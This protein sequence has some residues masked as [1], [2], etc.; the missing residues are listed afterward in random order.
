MRLLHGL[1]VL[2]SVNFGNRCC[3]MPTRFAIML[4]QAVVLSWDSFLVPTLLVD[5]PNTRQPFLRYLCRPLDL[6]LFP[7]RAG[8]TKSA[9]TREIRL[10]TTSS[11]N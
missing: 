2:K 5:R 1:L 6:H 10:P 8:A 7:D 4:G 3:F 11:E 9:P